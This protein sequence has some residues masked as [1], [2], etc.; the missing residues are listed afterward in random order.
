MFSIAFAKLNV[1]KR[2]YVTTKD[3]R[4]LLS[5]PTFIKQIIPSPAACASLCSIKKVCCYASYDR[6]TN[7]CDIYESC[8][9]ESEPSADVLI[10]QKSTGRIPSIFNFFDLE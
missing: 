1:V 5:S 4:I 10:L 3:R 8:C 6:N 7:Q 9:Q 2:D